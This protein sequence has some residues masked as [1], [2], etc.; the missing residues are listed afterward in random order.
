MGLFDENDRPKAKEAHRLGEDLDAISVDE[1]ERRIV[2][3]KA[4]I[5]R[6]EHEKTK[7]ARMR[8]V[9]DAVFKL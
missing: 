9:A 4:E 5:A 7:K 3:L 8:G 6:L 2:E 1:I